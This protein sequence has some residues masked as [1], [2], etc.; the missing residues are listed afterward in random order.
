VIFRDWI[1]VLLH[2]LPLALGTAVSPALLGASLELLARF[3]RRG[4]RMLLLYLLGAALVVASVVAISLVLP[5]K[6]AAGGSSII[7]DIVDIALAALLLGIA[8]VLIFRRPATAGA[9]A[10]PTPKA[11]PQSRWAGVGVLGLG[12]FMM[13]TNF[14]TLVLLL[15]GS[16]EVTSASVAPVIRGL[17]YGLL[18]VGALAPILLPLVWMLVRPAAAT[19][20][21][22]RINDAITRHGRAIGIVVSLATAAYLLARGF[23][24]F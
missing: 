8:G 17:G 18:A 1:T 19:R 21:L 6:S 11:H 12:V 22:G 23:G 7:S 15:A 14:S 24:L 13:V 2:I 3:G 20:D 4:V 10:K 16:H 5:Q 9:S